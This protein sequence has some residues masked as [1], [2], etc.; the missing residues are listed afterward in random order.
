MLGVLGGRVY[1]PR[2]G[3][4]GEIRDIWVKDGRVVPPEEVDREPAEIV[5]ATGLVVMPGG[6]D[7]HSHIAGPR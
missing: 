3:S 5:D 7:I 2:N 4:D 1:D 6:V